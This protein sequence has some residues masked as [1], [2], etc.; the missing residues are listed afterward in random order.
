[1]KSITT[2]QGHCFEAY[3]RVTKCY[4]RIYRPS[5]TYPTSRTECIIKDS[6]GNIYTTKT[7]K[8]R[9]MSDYTHQYEFTFKENEKVHKFFF[10][11]PDFKNNPFIGYYQ[12][13]E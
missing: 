1:M 13:F 8:I 10:C 2:E 12:T 5:L 9:T 11:E 4:F 7:Y 3:D 6:E